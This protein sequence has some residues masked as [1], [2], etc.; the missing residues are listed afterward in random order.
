[1][2]FALVCLLAILSAYHF[3]KMLFFRLKVVSTFHYVDLSFGQHV[4]LSI[5]HFVKKKKLR[6]HHFFKFA[7]SQKFF[8]QLANLSFSNSVNLLFHQ[9]APYLLME[10]FTYS[11]DIA[12]LE[13]CG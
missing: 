13:S 7:I 3:I 6:T 5:Y 12:S 2:L 4:F 9:R 11:S 8:S 10:L 1:V